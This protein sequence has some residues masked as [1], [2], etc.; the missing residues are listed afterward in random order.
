MME[1]LKAAVVNALDDKVEELKE[2][3]LDQGV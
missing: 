2:I 3:T 1:S